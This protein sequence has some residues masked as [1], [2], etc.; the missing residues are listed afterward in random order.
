MSPASQRGHGTCWAWASAGEARAGRPKTCGQAGG[1]VWGPGV[2]VRTE[3]NRAH[4]SEEGTPGTRL[5]RRPRCRAHQVGQQPGVHRPQMRRA[6][7]AWL[8]T[9]DS[10]REELVPEGRALLQAE[11]DPTWKS[12][13]QPCSATQAQTPGC[14]A[15]SEAAIGPSEAHP[16][17][18]PAPWVQEVQ[19][20]PI[21]SPAPAPL[22]RAAGRLSDAAGVPPHPRGP[23][24]QQTLRPQLPLRRSP[25]SLCLCGSTRRS[26]PG[27]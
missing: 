14:L 22:S 23:Q 5:H 24:T 16:R 9:Y 10:P 12:S 18:Q 11:E 27:R 20:D 25:A 8:E 3:E 19:D 17:P 1:E 21:P 7:A 13:G 4:G 15:P 6:A 2:R 26:E